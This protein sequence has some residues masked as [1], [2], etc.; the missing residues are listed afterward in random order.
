MTGRVP[1]VAA[2]GLVLGGLIVAGYFTDAALGDP[3]HTFTITGDASLPL[4]PGTSQS[5]DLVFTNPEASPI[6]VAAGSVTIAI[7][8]TQADCSASA[9]FAVPQSLTTNVSVPADSTESLSDLSV[10][11]AAWPVISMVETNVDQGAC[12]GA[13]LALT[14]TGSASG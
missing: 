13:P 12:E 3:P 4:F 7:A 2:L 11:R 6:T 14:Y 8:T 5:L 9:N 10:P 1:A